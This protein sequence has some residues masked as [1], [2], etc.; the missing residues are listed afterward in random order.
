MTVKHKREEWF[1]FSREIL[2]PLLD[3]R[4]ELLHSLTRH[5]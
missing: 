5:S 3:Q 2:A 4:N 1:Q